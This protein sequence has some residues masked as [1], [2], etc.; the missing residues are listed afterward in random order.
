MYSTSIKIRSADA[1]QKH[2]IKNNTA[3]TGFEFQPEITIRAEKSSKTEKK[4]NKI[5]CIQMK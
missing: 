4:K 5:Y 1:L 3:C 2:K